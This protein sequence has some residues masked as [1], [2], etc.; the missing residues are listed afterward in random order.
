MSR[1]QTP[2]LHRL[3]RTLL[4]NQTV[5]GGDCQGVSLLE[6]LVAMLVVTAVLA[7]ITPSIFLAVATRVQARRA[8]QA[9]QLAQQEVERV[10]LLM[11][12][13]NDAAYLNQQ[14]PASAAGDVRN[15]AVPASFVTTCS[16]QPCPITEALISSSS[17][18]FAVQ[19]F[20]DNPGIVN[21]ATGELQGFRVGVRVYSTDA[22]LGNGFPA[23]LQRNTKGIG[24]T[25]AQGNRL[26]YPLAALYV[27]ISKGDS[28]NNALGAYRTYLTP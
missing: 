21:S 6:V 1:P 5:A 7:S 24:L 8:E 25:T 11:N 17:D 20:R 23:N 4:L 12:Q 3:I 13:P 15:F 16:A 27:E 9:L 10:R 28:T 14:L 2:P 19:M 18:Q 26:Y 22:R